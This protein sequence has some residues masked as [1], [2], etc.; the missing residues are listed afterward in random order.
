MGRIGPAVSKITDAVST[1]VAPDG[2]NSVTWTI[3]AEGVACSV[4]ILSGK[5]KLTGSR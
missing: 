2:R 4:G 5:A 1:F 3:P